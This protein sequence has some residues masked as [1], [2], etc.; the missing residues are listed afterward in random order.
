MQNYVACTVIGNQGEF[1][2]DPFK[3]VEI[4]LRFKFQQRGELITAP[5]SQKEVPIRPA[6]VYV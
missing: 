3:V 6:L 1:I 4:T 2:N 5:H